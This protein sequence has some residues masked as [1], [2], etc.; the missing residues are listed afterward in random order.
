[1]VP[2]LPPRFPLLRFLNRTSPITRISTSASFSTTPVSS[3]SPTETFLASSNYAE[4]MYQIWKE[5]P[6]KVH[7]SWDIFFKN[8]ENQSSS[9]DNIIEQI[10]G[11]TLERGLS[12]P[13]LDFGLTG[14]DGANLIH[15]IR[16]FQARGHLR[17]NLDPLGLHQPNKEDLENLRPEAFGFLEKDLDREVY[18]PKVPGVDGILNG[19][20]T[21]NKTT[22]IRHVLNALICTYCNTV[23][24]EY[25]HIA[26]REKV[27]FI[28]T[29]IEKDFPTTIDVKQLTWGRFLTKEEKFQV[30]D[31][32]HYAELFEK[33]LAKRW[34]TTRRFGLE[35]L[36]AVIPGLKLFIDRSSEVGVQNFVI[37]MSHRGR[38]N[39]LANVLRKPLELIYSEF[40]GTQ[41]D[42]KKYYEEN[43][44]FE[45]SF[46]TGDVKY[47]LGT[48]YTRQYLDGRKIHLSLL[49]NP[50]HLEAV[51]PVVVGKVRAKQFYDGDEFGEKTCPIL[52]HGDAAFAGQGVIYE[53]MQL[54]QLVNYSTGGTLHVILNNQIGFT[55]T[56]EDR[57]STTYASDIGRTFGCPIFHCNADDP[58]SVAYCFKVAANW[59]KKYLSDVIVDVIG[60]RRAGHNEMDEARFTQ[61]LMYDKIRSH[62]TILSLY[63]QKCLED[64]LV[65]EQE[66]KKIGENTEST[67]EQ[68]Y[69]RAKQSPSLVTE[70]WLD[71][72]WKGFKS[73][74]Q[75]TSPE[76]SGTGV[77]DEVLKDI[78]GKCFGMLP[79]NFSVHRNVKKLMDERLHAIRTGKGLDWG[80]AEHLAFGSLCLEGNHVRLS[81]QDS[82]RGTFSHRHVVLHDLKTGG[83]YIPLNNIAISQAKFHPCNSPLSEFA[84]T[85][86]ELGFSL[87]NPNALILWEAQF[88]DFANGAQVIM[89]Q[90]ISSGETKWLRQ[91]GIVWL[92]PHGYDGQG[93]EHSSCRLERYLQLSDDPRDSISVDSS[94]DDGLLQCQ[95]SNIQ[96]CN[97]TNPAQMFHLL[98]RQIHREFR[99]PLIIATPKMLLRYRECVSNLEDFSTGTRFHR[100]LFEDEPRV[101]Q[102]DSKKIRKLVFASGKL[103]Y[104]LIQ[105]RAEIGAWDVAFVRIEQLAP[106]PYDLIAEAVKLYPNATIYFAQEEPQNMGPWIFADDR[107]FTATRLLLGEGR[108]CAYIGRK[109]SASPAIGY[110]KVHDLEQ[111]DL[112]NSVFD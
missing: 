52:I 50:S 40:S 69:L 53:T 23:G 96:I 38:L 37:G 47:H 61:P 7:S 3:P 5:D 93:P 88:G 110:G 62:P 35:G 89:D 77:A 103:F 1:M 75:E 82:Q 111:N 9:T 29:Q 13:S 46:M 28:R 68:A 58:D 95:K 79:D 84:V 31:R 27:N 107:I 42:A 57:G 81:G 98:R 51:D 55:T 20:L 17:A 39:V 2:R 15:L 67:L 63:S 104:Q 101:K 12:T 33:F 99:K 10:Q 90:F 76:T 59:R 64:T 43:K 105:K 92:L 26:N 97:P 106:F 60:Y 34:A 112:I 70:D 32:L 66:L 44:K 85:G 65:T 72:R 78:G 8:L 100:V 30:L 36:E 80:A 22:T 6:T 56:P 74:R 4:E 41:I 109:S 49:A 108:R 94:Q 18:L 11:K 14:D 45:Y 87:E 73:P 21:E 83:E 48:S 54:S 25:L 91:T 16:G 24:V 19:G 86:F 102:L 71:S